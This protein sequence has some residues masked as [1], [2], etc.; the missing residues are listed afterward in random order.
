M[1]TTADRTFMRRALR[2]AARGAGRVSPNPMVGAVIVR[3]GKAIASGWHRGPGKDHAEAD[4][5]KK[6]GF[7]AKGC[8]VYVNLEP[9]CH[10]DEGKRTPPCVPALV[11]AG[12]RRVVIGTID[13]NPRVAGR[14]LETLRKSGVEVVVGVLEDECR[15]LNA[16]FAKWVTTGRPRVTLKM[17]V[18]LDGRVADRWGTSRWVTCEA[19]RDRVHRMR[20]VSDAVIVGLG[21]A[22]LDD[23][24]LLP[25]GLRG[26]HNP[27]RVVLDAEALLPPDSQLART[28]DESPVIVMARQ[29]ADARRIATLEGAGIEVVR[30]PSD[31][32]RLDL[33]ALLDALGRRGIT[34]ILA[35]GGA[36]LAASL[37]KEGRVDELVLFY[38]PRLLADPEAPAFAADMGIRKLS[39]AQGFDVVSV[40]RSGSD[41]CVIL[42]PRA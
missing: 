23:P 21:T 15:R 22:R 35:E 7:D 41:V 17:G 10:Q 1:S 20:S 42:Q 34:S 25:R 24:L 9:C 36:T 14:G 3:D 6:V 31:G 18:T 38:A 4:A 28:T 40:E 5:L 33:G 2:L 16:A 30:L 37:L 32:V 13:P 12:V 39:D 29:G 27:V 19:S 26:G 8:D 11:S